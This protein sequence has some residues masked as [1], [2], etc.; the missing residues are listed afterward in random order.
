MDILLKKYVTYLIQCDLTREE[1]EKYECKRL[2][3]R[4]LQCFG[5]EIV[6]ANQNGKIL[7]KLFIVQT[8]I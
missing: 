6:F 4:L 1:A 3:R 8:L 2:K 7:V 5:N